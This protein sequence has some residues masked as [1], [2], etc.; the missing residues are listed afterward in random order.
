MKDHE[1]MPLRVAVTLAKSMTEGNFTV[2]QKG[3]G[4]D[5]DALSSCCSGHGGVDYCGGSICVCNDQH[6]CIKR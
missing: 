6:V 5:V 2:V 4:G 1:K 3:D